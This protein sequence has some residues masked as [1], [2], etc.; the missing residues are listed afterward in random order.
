VLS[1]LDLIGMLEERLGR[2]IPLKWADWR[3][4]DQ[5]VYISDIRKL[6][7]SLNWN[8]EIDV[9]SGIAQLI[10]WVD[11][12]RAAVQSIGNGLQTLETQPATEK[13]AA[14]AKDAFPPISSSMERHD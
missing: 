12:N 3:P 5:Q 11:R 13:I 10:D 14:S 4:G 7:S 9:T 1:L 6:E 8:P 2:E